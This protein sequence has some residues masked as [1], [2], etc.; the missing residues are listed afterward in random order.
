M[1][2]ATFRWNKM[3][4]YLK[5]CDYIMNADVRKPCGVSAAAANKIVD[6]GVAAE[7]VNILCPW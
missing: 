3:K 5:T 1:D 2:K 6:Q 4:K 7:N